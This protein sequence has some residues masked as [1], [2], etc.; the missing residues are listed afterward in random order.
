MADE[1]TTATAEEEPQ[2]Q[3]VE[4]AAPESWRDGLSDDLKMDAN[5]LKFN[6]VEGLAK[7]YINAQ[8]MIGADK[9]AIP[10]KH[11]TSDEWGEVY[12]KLGRPSEADGYEL[13]YG[14]GEDNSLIGEYAEAVH[15]AGLNPQQAQSLLDWYTGVEQR[16]AQLQDDA[17]AQA[18]DDGMQELR[19]EWGRAF[20]Q[21]TANAQRAASALLGSTEMFDEVTLAD[22]RKL[23]DHPAIVKMFASLADQIS[24]DTM[25]GETTE[26]AFTPDEAMRKIA[27]ITAP[28]SPY[29]D[30][31][32][33]QHM[34]M[35]EEALRLREYAYPDAEA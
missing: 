14:E 8:R 9:V 3:P 28:N 35:V 31:K 20:D 17:A 16:G 32:H 12:S 33:P 6:D 34:L 7:S 10:G 29:W 5:L 22:G 30:K 13:N 25:Q 19:Q 26:T 27:E 21:K 1:Q 24:E 4:A 2:S 11:A 15:S 23:G 18:T